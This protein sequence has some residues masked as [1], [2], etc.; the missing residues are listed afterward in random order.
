MSPGF[1]AAALFVALVAGPRDD[2]DE[3]IARLKGVAAAAEN[4]KDRAEAVEA[5][6]RLGPP[7]VPA[8][9][10]LLAA[11]EPTTKMLALNALGNQRPSPR[12]R[13]HHPAWRVVPDMIRLLDD[14]DIRVRRQAAFDL[15]AFWTAPGQGPRPGDLG[16]S[17]VPSLARCV[18]DDD[19]RLRLYAARLLWRIAEVAWVA[20][21]ALVVSLDDEDP[22]VA[23]AAQRTLLFLG[24]PERAYS[25]KQLR[26]ILEADPPAPDLPAPWWGELGTGTGPFPAASQP[27]PGRL[28]ALLYLGRKAA[29]PAARELG[30]LLATLA[31]GD[32]PATPAAAA[33]RFHALVAR[34]KLGLAEESPIA[35]LEAALRGDDPEAAFWAAH[36]LVELRGAD[37]NEAVGILAA[38]IPEHETI[39]S[40]K[41]PTP[42]QTLARIKAHAAALALRRLGL[43]VPPLARPR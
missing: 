30:P 23:R 1:A 31:A 36:A 22:E 20:V 32:P 37:A 6:K 28:E 15:G 12:D 18:R 10:E 3:E 33:V 39:L 7:A 8:L 35:T 16:R 25:A 14:A 26:A 21:P 29:D 40:R 34:A 43:H 13:P 27:T 42:A 5:L 2:V 38:A 41:G 9:G 19:P 11:A 4:A 17:A 24:P